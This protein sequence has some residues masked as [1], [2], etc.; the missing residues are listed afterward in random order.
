MI[1]E[2]TAMVSAPET[3]A[4]VEKLRR[5]FGNSL[6]AILFY[7]SCLRSGN[8]RD[9]ILDLYVLVDSYN[10]AYR[11]A[12]LAWLNKLLPPNVF[13]LETQSENQLIRA[14]YAV[15]TLDDFLRGTSRRWYHSYLWGRFTQPIGILYY[16]SESILQL[17]AK[18]R[19]QSAVT[20]L[21]RVIPTL[22]PSF[23][24]REL[25][26]QAFTL[27]YSAELRPERPGYAAGLYDVDEKYYDRLTCLALPALPFRISG[28]GAASHTYQA[29]ISAFSRRGCRRAWKIRKIQ[30][31]ILS[32]LRLLKALLTFHGGVSYIRWK[33]ERHAGI[34][35]QK[36][37]EG[38]PE[39]FFQLC[40]SFWRAYRQGGFR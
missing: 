23:T 36:P 13:Y 26:Q 9:G 10:N 25:W 8:Y 14:K 7:G 20:F 31:K 28:G 24:A 33:V 39:T 16:R 40:R 35:F 5:Q 29:L 1:H 22:P 30:G 15:L 4:L 17:V 34:E 38:K 2:Q 11:K 3:S 6:R 18:A 27:S 19:A 12:T 21:T 37:A 32:I